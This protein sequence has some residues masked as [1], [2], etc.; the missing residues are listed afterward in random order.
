MKLEIGVCLKISLFIG[1]IFDYVM[2]R[3][4]EV[5]DMEE[6]YL[7]NNVVCNINVFCF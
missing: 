3:G 6:D 5:V 7:K 2:V 4:Y 1:Y